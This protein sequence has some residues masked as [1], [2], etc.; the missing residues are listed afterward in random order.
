MRIYDAYRQGLLTLSQYQARLDAGETPNAIY[1]GEEPETPEY[2]NYITGTS[3]ATS[4]SVIAESVINTTK[5]SIV[6]KNT[7]TTNS[8][9]AV[10][11]FYIT[12]ILVRSVSETVT[13]STTFLLETEYVASDVSV[14]ISDTVSGSHSTYEIGIVA[15]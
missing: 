10:I 14:K 13:H 9:N 6:I 2:S 7:G 3:I 4:V 11:E 5:Q 15:F 8:I 12:D 1:I